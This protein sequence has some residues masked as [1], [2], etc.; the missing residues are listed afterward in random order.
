MHPKPHKQFID[1]KTSNS[2]SNGKGPTGAAPPPPLNTPAIACPAAASI[3]PE[4]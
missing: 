1:A 3:D 2:L 4:I